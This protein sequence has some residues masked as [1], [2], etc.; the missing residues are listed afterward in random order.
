[1]SLILW[2]F[3]PLC[4]IPLP[5]WVLDEIKK[6]VELAYCDRF[7]RRN[8]EYICKG[9]ILAMSSSAFIGSSLILKKKGLKRFAARGT[10]AGVG[11]YTYLL[12]PL[13]WAG[14]VTMIIGEIA[15][16]VAY[17][18]APAVLVTPLSAL[19]IIVRYY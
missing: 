3:V 8:I 9:L 19:S 7:G 10:H 15:N 13:W 1:M 18:Y 17:I 6:D 16:F 4:R 12:E 14:M 2:K 5:L 11:G